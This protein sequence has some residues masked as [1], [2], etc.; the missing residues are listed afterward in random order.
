[1]VGMCPG[2]RLFLH[3]PL[4]SDGLNG[5]IQREMDSNDVPS[6]LQG[7]TIALAV[8]FDNLVTI[9][10]SST[11]TRTSITRYCHKVVCQ[12]GWMEYSLTNGGL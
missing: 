11:R 6:S 2:M 8:R 1:M 4:R 10:T 9:L 12:N 3:I 5:H 7:T